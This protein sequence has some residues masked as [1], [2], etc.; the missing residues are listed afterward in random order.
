MAVLV[1]VVVVIMLLFVPLVVLLVL[2]VAVLAA[3]ATRDGFRRALA[4]VS[5]LHWLLFVCVLWLGASP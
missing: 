1:A 3:R 4:D 5:D 2:V